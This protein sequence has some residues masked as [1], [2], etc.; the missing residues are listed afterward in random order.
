MLN[1]D[2]RHLL[3]DVLR[4]PPGHRLD[5][6]L[7]TTYSLDLT[8]LLLAPLSMAAYDHG[9]EGLESAAPHELLE[10]IRRHAEHTTVLCQ[11]GGIVVPTTYRKLTVFIEDSVV[12][13]MPP[14]GRVFHPK[15]W[16]LRFVSV[17]GQLHHRLACLS[18]NLTGDRSWDTVLVADET[19]TAPHQMS[20]APAAA[21]IDDLLD[22]TVRPV[23]DAR[24]R[25]L[26]DLTRTLATCSLA[27]PEP[28]TS[29][30]LLPLGLTP[31]DRWPLPEEVERAVVISPFLDVTTVRRLPPGTTIISRPE[32]F[33]RIGARDLTGHDL[34]VLQPQA[35]SLC[36]DVSSD[37]GA[38]LSNES[39]LEVKTGL[40]AKVIAWDA[41]GESGLLTG[42]ANATSAAFGGNIEFGVVLTGPRSRCGAEAILADGD[43]R[44]GFTRL[45]QPYSPPS[46]DGAPDPRYDLEREIEAHHAR[47]AEAGPLLTTVD[48]PDGL[49]LELDWAD[50]PP[51][52]GETTIRPITVPA[53]LARDIDKHPSWAGL[54]NSDLTPFVAVRTTL[55]RDGV[56]VERLSTIRADLIGAPDD[57]A[58]RVLREALS[59]VEDV[60]RYL[61]L[62]LSDP[63][64]DD[65]SDLLG[66]TEPTQHSDADDWR[67]AL[68]DLVLL[69]PLVRAFGRDDDG[70]DR[71]AS[72]LDDLRD[73]DG[74]LPDLGPDFTQLW[75][76]VNT[77]RGTR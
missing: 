17:D 73:E 60:I 55:A 42:S 33:D 52:L 71:V 3:T 34:R 20:A 25:H 70:L 43:Q 8:S 68:D 49:A 39:T 58:R 75:D 19:S 2:T 77:A 66:L 44:A 13:V 10:A 4:P 1:P 72:L 29:G 65:F 12:E 46:E 26:R 31:D 30:D 76:V 38:D 11:A 9:P 47:L 37:S 53:H 32:A 64:L 63:G 74:E 27:V 69:E 24:R 61:A 23:S 14:T 15:I 41:V 5:S 62:L 48:G 54:G 67:P 7:A 45:L 57:R 50:L 18:R 56:T 28:F 51:S 36:L 40:H 35:D 21:F 6:A 59:H 22:R 16:A